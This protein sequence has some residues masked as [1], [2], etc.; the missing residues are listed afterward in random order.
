M[1]KSPS[2]QNNKSTARHDDVDIHVLDH[3]INDLEY[4][5]FFTNVCCVGTMNYSSWIH[6]TGDLY[7]IAPTTTTVNSPTPPTTTIVSKL[8]NRTGIHAVNWSE[9]Y[10]QTVLCGN[11]DG[12]MSFWQVNH[13]ERLASVQSDKGY[14]ISDV[15]WNQLDHDYLLSASLSSRIQLFHIGDASNDDDDED[16]DNK[17]SRDGS[18]G[19]GMWCEGVASFLEHTK[20]VNA[21]RWN[22]NHRDEFA[23][24]SDDG[25]LKIWD[26]RMN[27]YS[28]VNTMADRSSSGDSSS[29]GGGGSSGLTC[30]DWHKRDDWLI[31]VGDRTG[32][33]LLWDTRNSLQPLQRRVAH[34]S[35]H[36]HRSA[37][38]KSSVNDLRFDTNDCDRLVT[39]SEDHSL[40]IWS[41][42]S[43]SKRSSQQRQQ[44]QQQPQQQQKQ[45]GIYLTHEHKFHRRAVRA[46]DWNIHNADS[47]TSGA[48]D[49]SFINCSLARMVQVTEYEKDGQLIVCIFYFSSFRLYYV[50]VHTYTSI[51]VH[52]IGIQPFAFH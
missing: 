27:D 24:V 47:I 21:I 1:Q 48:A 7:L 37:T 2:A 45:Q 9:F 17:T 3:E 38:T 26:R 28:S 32:Q 44:Q 10:T 52:C 18:G 22:T 41:M 4:S 30:L 15:D 46:V 36:H 6:H 20:S 12:S 50:M 40:R 42:S 33:V 16:K 49:H 31:G 14:A 11:H 43:D 39:C 8:R 13:G 35:D 23:S 29:G 5:T 19:G 51:A 34:G 25:S